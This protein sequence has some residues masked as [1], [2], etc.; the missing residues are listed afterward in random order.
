MARSFGLADDDLRRGIAA[1]EACLYIADSM[2]TP[3]RV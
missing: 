2:L 3:V 1:V